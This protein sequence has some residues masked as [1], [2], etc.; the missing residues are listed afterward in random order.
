MTTSNLSYKTFKYEL[1]DYGWGCGWRTLQ[2]CISKLYNFEISIE[3]IMNK[4]INKGYKFNT[5]HY[6]FLD[7]K[8]IIDFFNN[9]PNLEVKEIDIYNNNDI[10]SICN[11]IKK[12]KYDNY[13]F[14]GIII[15]DGY[16]VMIDDIDDTN[17][18][19]IIDPHQNPNIKEFI[20]LNEIGHG[21]IGWID[22]NDIIY[23]NINKLGITLNKEDYLKLN[24]PTFYIIK[25]IK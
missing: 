18:L 21:G 1:F 19:Y 9:Y 6:G 23:K 22:I 25:L 3:K 10:D 7:G 12:I 5:N 13:K 16:I 17:K 11:I 24:T 14:C 8:M 2:N 15:H 20:K 4:L